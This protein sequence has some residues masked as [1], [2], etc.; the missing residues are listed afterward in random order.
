MTILTYWNILSSNLKSDIMF[1]QRTPMLWRT[2]KHTLVMSV[3]IQ[4]Y[5]DP[6]TGNHTYI[7]R[8]KEQD[9]PTD[10]SD[11]YVAFRSFASAVDFICTNFNG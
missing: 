3:T 1:N 5:T 7:V 11:R 6:R 2:T 9:D 10:I 8:W 4:H